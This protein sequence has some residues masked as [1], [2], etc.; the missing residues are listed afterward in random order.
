MVE[1]ISAQRPRVD[2][3]RENFTAMTKVIPVRIR[4]EYSINLP[5]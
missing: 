1:W 2:Q 3:T 5:A 4:I